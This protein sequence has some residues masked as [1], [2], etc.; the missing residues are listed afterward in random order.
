MERSLTPLASDSCPSERDDALPKDQESTRRRKENRKSLSIQVRVTP[1]QKRILGE[2]ATKNGLGLSSWL[3]S[4]GL[5]AA[6]STKSE[7]NRPPQRPTVKKLS[8]P[9][10]SVTEAADP[11]AT[12][13][14]DSNGLEVRDALVGLGFKRA[15]ADAAVTEARNR[16]GVEAAFQI[17]MRE[18][19]KFCPKPTQPRE[20]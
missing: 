7:P 19:L 14:I 5:C 18:A 3:L 1:E 13:S 6:K 12:P 15:V 2:A 10:T 20:G 4:T 8:Q 17:W 11:T 16:L 9:P